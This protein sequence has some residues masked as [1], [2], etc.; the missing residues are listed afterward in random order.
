[1]RQQ[2][3]RVAIG[4]AVIV[5]VGCGGSS[6]VTSSPRVDASSARASGIASLAPTSALSATPT[7]PPTADPSVKPSPGTFT[8]T[9]APAYKPTGLAP[10]PD[11]RV[12]AVSDAGNPLQIYDPGTGRFTMGP[13]PLLKRLMPRAI[14]LSDGRVLI[15]GTSYEAA[16][17]KSYP[18]GEIYN[19]A[20][21]KL[22]PTGPGDGVPAKG[23]SMVLLKNGQVLFAGG[24][25]PN[26]W[27]HVD[28]AV[29][30][31]PKTNTFKP[32]GRMTEAR[33]GAGAV[34]LSDGRALLVDDT[35]AEIYDPRTSSFGKAGSMVKQNLNGY[36]TARRYWPTAV[37]LA[38]GRVL[39]VGGEYQ[40]EVSSGGIPYAQIYNPK[41][42]KFSVTG[43][44]DASRS[45]ALAIRLKDGRILVAG[46]GGYTGEPSAEIFDPASGT[47]S[48]TGEI[49]WPSSK[50]LGVLLR[51]GSVLVTEDG[52]G[53]N[54]A[55]ERYWP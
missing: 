13:S 27:Q 22:S 23:R 17:P 53:G 34:A 52:A 47:F 37:T 33:F 12:L 55:A 39:V 5:V 42:R 35:S 26:D 48:S 29:L 44:M 7:A 50:P 6:T 28:R 51:D 30:F 1:M 21:G 43:S 31:D 25:D 45:G 19:P 49:A 2:F 15:V 46:G 4:L 11:G 36:M 32:T 8:M 18:G 9:G 14:A 40:G 20:T 24:Q 16:D 38:D 41:T 10:L 54:G 3:R